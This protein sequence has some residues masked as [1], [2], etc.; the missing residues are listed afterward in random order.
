MAKLKSPVATTFGFEAH[1]FVT[2]INNF[3][4]KHADLRAR[5]MAQREWRYRQTFEPVGKGGEGD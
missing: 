1:A 4:S 2:E 5:R 3:K